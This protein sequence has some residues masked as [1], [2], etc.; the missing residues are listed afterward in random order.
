MKLLAGMRAYS[1]FTNSFILR[2]VLRNRS[3]SKRCRSSI[4]MYFWMKLLMHI[5]DHDW[6][7][8]FIQLHSPESLNWQL[9][10]HIMLNPTLI[11]KMWPKVYWNVARWGPHIVNSVVITSVQTSTTPAFDTKCASSAGLA[12]DNRC[13]I[14]YPPLVHRNWFSVSVIWD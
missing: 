3:C 9:V 8:W 2:F 10:N 1:Q 4:M 12:L 13:C 11:N 7:K 6:F 14:P 5:S